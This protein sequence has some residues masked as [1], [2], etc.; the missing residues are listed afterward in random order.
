MT[1]CGQPRN[2]YPGYKELKKWFLDKYDI[3]V[4]MHAWEDKEFTKYDFFDEGKVQKTYTP[5]KETY[6]NLLDWYKPKAYH[7]EKG[8]TFEASDIMGP[9]H[10]RVNSQISFFLSLKRAWDLLEESGIKYDYVIRARYDLL[11]THQ[12]GYTTDFFKDIRIFDPSKVYY[13]QYPPHW[14]SGLGMNDIFAIGGYEAMKV[15]HNV[16]PSQ[17]YTQFLDPGF[18]EWMRGLDKYVNETVLL[19]HLNK[20]NIETVETDPVALTWHWGAKVIR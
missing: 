18:D 17:I 9:N 6:Q 12:V 7:F 10:Q 4:Y 1:L 15:Y 3:D 2:I 5:T 14:R 13:F 20:N 8:M 11:F 19:Y 16:S